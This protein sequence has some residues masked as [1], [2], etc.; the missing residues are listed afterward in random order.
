MKININN[1]GNIKETEIIIEGITVVAGKNNTGKSTICKALYSMFNAF[2]N[3]NE[4]IKRERINSISFALQYSHTSQGDIFFD[5]PKNIRDSISIGL[6]KNFSNKNFNDTEI[7]EFIEKNGFSHEKTD[8]LIPRISEILKIS[9]KQIINAFL[10]RIFNVEFNSQIH[11]INFERMGSVSLFI[12]DKNFFV[13][14]DKE[15]KI[16]SV[17]YPHSLQQEIIYLDDPFVLDQLIKKESFFT[18]VSTY[19][20]H[21][22]QLI[23]KLSQNEENNVIDEIVVEEKLKK[24]YEKINGV[25]DGYIEQHESQSWFYRKK[26]ENKRLNVKNLSTGLKTFVILKTLLRKGIII[27]HGTILLDEPEIHLHPEWQLLFAEIIVLLQKEFQMHIL[28][29]THSPYFL[30]AIEVYSKKYNIH[31]N[32]HFYL[33]EFQSKELKIN[34]VTNRVEVIYKKLFEPFQTLEDEET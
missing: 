17:D 10:S 24:I 27:S 14:F 29:S 6:I 34:E 3:L 8:M 1:I 20:N 21:R 23:E 28:L 16:V 7:R 18:F 12:K 33:A 31:N 25:C 2:Y 32:C 19:K 15:N 13:S 22:D 5:V 9:D 30:R 26:N 11:N 4:K